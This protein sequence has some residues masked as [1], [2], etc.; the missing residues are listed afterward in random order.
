VNRSRWPLRVIVV[1][2][3]VIAAVAAWEY[4]ELR[5]LDGELARI[6]GRREPTSIFRLD[7]PSFGPE[8]EASRDYRAAAALVR[9]A[10]DP[11]RLNA[12]LERAERAN[13]WP[14]D[15]VAAMEERVR[16]N[17][18]AL[19]YLDKAAKTEFDGFPEPT[20]YVTRAFDLFDLLQVVRMR[21]SLLVLAA[22]GDDAAR[23]LHAALRLQRA[24]TVWTWGQANRRPNALSQPGQIRTGRAR[25]SDG[26]ATLI[27]VRQLEILLARTRPSRDALVVLA[28]G[29]AALD[30]DDLLRDD[31]L[32]L[33]ASSRIT[34]DTPLFRP[35]LLHRQN[36]NLRDYSRAIDAQSSRKW[37]DKLDALTGF[38]GEL[39]R[40]IVQRA[41]AVAQ[42]LAMIRCARTVVAIEQFKREHAETLPE[43]VTKLNVQPPPVD[44]F[45]GQPLRFTRDAAGYVVYSVGIDRRDGGPASTS[46]IA[47]RV[48]AS[49]P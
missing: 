43:D 36:W 40:A 44:P 4:V 8:S 9:P 33:R 32:W 38:E 15:L 27:Q 17:S 47:V 16:N 29:F 48:Q 10:D 25:R 49:N 12:R 7:A 23:S 6:E 5:R 35:L 3:T 28:D 14:P 19:G 13:D 31:L 41:N 39:G 45:S 30:N 20:V 18:D 24:M 21:T 37:P 2:L 42:E 22:Q 11:N 46:E 1:L 26:I 34:L